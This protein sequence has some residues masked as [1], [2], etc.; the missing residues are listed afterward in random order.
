[1][2]E[3]LALL[4][5]D[6]VVRDADVLEGQQRR[7]RRVHPELLQALLADH[8]GQ[9]H[10]DEEQREAVVARVGVG[11]RDEDDV[12]RA[13]A[14]GDVGLRAVDDPLVAVADGRVLIPATS[15]PA[16]GSVIPSDA[17]FCPAIDG[18]R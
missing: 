2:V 8:A 7:V 6:R 16:S 11:L 14:V 4:A 9:V 10:V 5:E 17:I 12:V 13:V 15:D 1:V 18:T 3:A